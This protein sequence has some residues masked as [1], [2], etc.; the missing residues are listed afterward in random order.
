MIFPPS[1]AAWATIAGF[2]EDGTDAE[3]LDAKDA[4]ARLTA[5]D[6]PIRPLIGDM[7][8]LL[9]IQ[10]EFSST[11]TKSCTAIVVDGWAGMACVGKMTAFYFYLDKNI[12]IRLENR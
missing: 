11:V 8:I 1:A 6:D 2:S 3:A 10:V 12:N 4:I 9:S 5:L 7:A